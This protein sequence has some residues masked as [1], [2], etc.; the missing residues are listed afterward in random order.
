MIMCFDFKE[1]TFSIIALPLTIQ[2]GFPLHKN[3][4]TNYDGQIA[5]VNH[6]RME[7][8][9]HIYIWVLKEEGTVWEGTVELE[10]L[11]RDERSSA[12]E[13]SL[14]SLFLREEKY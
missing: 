12:F 10:K 3:I 1:E 13:E 4:L 7:E 8:K 5:V 9:T 14:F 11:D 6:D 2:T